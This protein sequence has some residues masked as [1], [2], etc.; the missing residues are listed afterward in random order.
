MDDNFHISNETNE[1]IRHSFDILKSCFK[2]S[3]F[4]Q[5]KESKEA[6]CNFF[7]KEKK[8]IVFPIEFDLMK[9]IGFLLKI[10]FKLEIFFWVNS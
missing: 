10:Y 6:F 9:R 1:K 8:A 4:S 5:I 7:A 2:K 3:E